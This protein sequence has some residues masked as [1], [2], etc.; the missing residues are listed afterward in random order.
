M[1]IKVVVETDCKRELVQTLEENT[2]KVCVK[3]K[4]ER[5]QANIRM[6]EMMS[7]ELQIEKK[8]LKI[9]TG[10]HHTNKILFVRNVHDTR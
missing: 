3:V 4:A 8:R 1:H 5:N 7:T 6:L 10:H 9:I 2:Y